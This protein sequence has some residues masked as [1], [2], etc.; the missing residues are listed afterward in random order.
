MLE[1]HEIHHEHF[2][3][4]HRNLG[5]MEPNLKLVLEE[6]QKSKE[7]LNRRFDKHNEE[8]NR[9]F[10]DLDRARA[11]RAAVVDQRFEALETAYSDIA[12]NIGKC[13]AD[14]EAVCINAE[15]DDRV[16]ALEVAA[17]DLGSWSLEVDAIIDDLKTEVQKLSQAHDRKVLDSQPPWLNVGTSPTSTPARAMAGA[18]VTTPSGHSAAMSRRD[19]GFGFASTRTNVPVTGV[20]PQTLL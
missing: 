9:H 11:D 13:V 10:T 8:W 16:T 12:S 14:L 17:M 7:D 18:T 1:P 15:R 20:S 19:V 4:L 6:I 3:R 2:T 5:A